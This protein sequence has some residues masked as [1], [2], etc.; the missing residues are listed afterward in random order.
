MYVPHIRRNEWV[1]YEGVKTKSLQELKILYAELVYQNL[2]EQDPATDWI[3]K[4]R[5]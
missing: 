1:T 3:S 2:F 4:V 5:V